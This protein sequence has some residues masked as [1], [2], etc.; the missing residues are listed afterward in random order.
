MIKRLEEEVEPP[1]ELEEFIRE[2]KTPTG[3]IRKYGP[4]IYGFSY[5]HEPGKE[6]EFKEFG[7]IRLEPQ[8]RIEPAMNGER[9][10]MTDVIEGKNSYEVVVELPGM[11]K[12]DIKLN[13][14]EN[15]LEI[16][17]ANG[18]KF[19]KE[20]SFRENV[21]PDSAKATY[22]NGVLSLLFKKKR[23]KGVFINLE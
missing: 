14:T 17:A 21:D 18:K 23:T 16:R 4:F 6:P 22:N 20:I 10:P 1:K 19:Y 2:E 5:T 9:E 3:T 8:G 7:N 15:S 12:S 11:N 13:A